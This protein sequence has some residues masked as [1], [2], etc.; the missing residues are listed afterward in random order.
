MVV[1]YSAPS[2]YQYQ[3]L[4]IVNSIGTHFN[5]IL[6]EIQIFPFTKTHFIISSA[7]WLPFCPVGDELNQVSKRCSRC[8]CPFMALSR[9]IRKKILDNFFQREKYTFFTLDIHD[10]MLL[11]SNTLKTFNI[12]I[13]GDFF[14]GGKLPWLEVRYK[15]Y[16]VKKWRLSVCFSRLITCGFIIVTEA[17]DSP[18]KHLRLGQIC[19]HLEDNI[20][21]CLGETSFVLIQDCSFNWVIIGSVY[22]LARASDM[23]FPEQMVTQCV[24]WRINVSPGPNGLIIYCVT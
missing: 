3:C 7:K 19:R 13:Y 1:A 22:G 23:P 24:N 2:H 21:I 17:S 4:V 5:E 6:I 14:N 12:F 11:V 10:I 20:C 15:A 8:L 16:L 9:L 18:L